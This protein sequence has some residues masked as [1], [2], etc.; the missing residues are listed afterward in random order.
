MQLLLSWYCPNTFRHV[1]S[2]LREGENWVPPEDEPLKRRLA[3]EFDYYGI[4]C[5]YFDGAAEVA[6]NLP[7]FTINF[8]IPQTATYW[9]NYFKS[10]GYE[11]KVI[12]P[13]KLIG[14]QV[15]VCL[16][17]AL[18]SK[19]KK[20]ILVTRKAVNNSSLRLVCVAL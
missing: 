20:E 14:V 2:F 18:Y 4:Q 6:S 11:I 1:L 12:I 9:N 7:T 8:E 13:F 16:L 15:Q 17:L 5:S 10:R 19:K 3:K